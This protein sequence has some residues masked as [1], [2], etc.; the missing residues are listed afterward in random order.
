MRRPRTPPSDRSW[1]E[2]ISGLRKVRGDKRVHRPLLTLFLLARAQHGQSNQVKF[3]DLDDSFREA[4]HEF[5][6]SPNP[7]GLEYPFWHLQNNGFW[8]VEGAEALPRVKNKDRPTRKGL[9]KYN[10][11]GYVPKNLWEELT[12]DPR[13]IERLACSILDEF[14]P[15]LPRTRVA[16]AVGLMV[17]ERLG[18]AAGH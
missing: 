5:P 18:R 8:E 2:L 11:K 6:P 16:D 12:S 9:V 1:D 15:D 7:S 3:N 13:L 14:W 17:Q 4:I 10:P